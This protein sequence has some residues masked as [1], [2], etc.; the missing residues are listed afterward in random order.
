MQTINILIYII[1]CKRYV[2]RLTQ[3]ERDRLED[4][5]SRGREAAYR[6]QHAQV[7]LLVDEGTNGPGLADRAAAEQVE[8]RC[9]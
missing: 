8:Q 5:V 2:V 9:C 3:E 1:I 4:L 7:L 6:R